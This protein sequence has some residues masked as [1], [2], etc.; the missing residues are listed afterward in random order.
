MG[1]SAS[2]HKV[3]VAHQFKGTVGSHTEGA[4]APVLKGVSTYRSQCQPLRRMSCTA[5]AQSASKNVCMPCAACR[6]KAVR[7]AQAK[8][9]MR[10]SQHASGK[11]GHM[12]VVAHISSREKS[13]A[14]RYVSS[15][16]YR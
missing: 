11:G 1:H 5:I 9:C 13:D 12:S 15:S 10:H 8:T 16:T 14:L 7:C 2:P 3:V 6:I 4:G